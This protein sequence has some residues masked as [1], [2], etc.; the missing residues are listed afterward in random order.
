[1][2]AARLSE[3]PHRQV[4]LIEAGPDYPDYAALPPDL[5]I[6]G[7]RAMLA[8]TH[9]WNYVASPS[10]EV[11]RTMPVPRGR[12]VGGS[13]S[14]NFALFARGTR[15]DFDAWAAAG[16]DEWSYEKV[17]PH[18][19]KLE[20]DL[21]YQNEFH[22]T[23]GPMTIGRLPREQW[24]S[25]DLLFEEACLA[26]GYPAYG[27]HNHPD[28]TGVG[29]VPRNS[30][31]GTR[32][33]TARVYLA[34]ARGRPNLHV[35]ADTLVL[36]VA[37]RGT[38]AIGVVVADGAAGAR[39]IEGDEIILSA[40]SINTPQL[41]MLSGIGPGAH[42]RSLG[43]DVVADLAGVGQ[44]MRDHPCVYVLAE[45]NPDEPYTLGGI[46]ATSNLYLRLTSSAAARPNNCRIM[47]PFESS[48]QGHQEAAG[49]YGMVVGLFQAV[50]R[51]QV[52]L[53]STDPTAPP[54]IDYRYLS[55]GIDRASLRE[56]LHRTIELLD[57][58]SMKVAIGPLL[59]PSLDDLSS[60]AALDRWMYRK[61]VT[62]HHTSSTAKLGPE[63]DPEAVVDQFGRVHGFEGLRVADASIMPDCVSHNTNKSCVMIGERVADFV[64]QGR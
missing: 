63:S 38:K 36:R 1:V 6:L 34:D 62:A 58:P 18:Y 11:R 57:Q 19:R 27:D 40:G 48:I 61:V 9:N 60:A 12:V 15:E 13:S 14:I 39:V 51:G 42:L 4:A 55:D 35:I 37:L 24:R 45:R 54:R 49:Y 16:N 5:Q 23:T 26:Q 17:L 3:D 2:L 46:T 22:G 44:N 33:S 41:L 10:D 29:P 21:D 59:E 28:S 30:Q 52:R 31:D 20:T 47:A 56:T 43:I 8:E 25:T 53:R 50:S 32:Y 64:T 7:S